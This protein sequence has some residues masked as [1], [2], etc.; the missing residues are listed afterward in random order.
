M[1]RKVLIAED[2]RSLR[3]I[4]GKALSS[5]GL[6]VSQ[7]GDGQQAY[8]LIAQGD[9]DVAIVDIKM[10]SLTG[11]QLLERVSELNHPPHV[12][13]ITA[14]NTMSNAIDA[15]KGGA[16]D[17]LCKPFDL[18]LFEELVLRAVKDRATPTASIGISDGPESASET[19]ILYG[20][21]PVMQRV[22]KAIG[23][24]AISP[25]SILISGDSGTGK[26]LVARILHQ[27]SPRS[28]GPF[29]AV[30]A[31]AIPPELLEADLFGHARGAF[32]GATTDN[33]GKFQAA[34]GGT[35][36][37]DE[38]GELPLGLQAKL[39]RVL[40]RKEFY[41]VGAHKE[42]QVDVRILVATNR[43]LGEEVRAGN[44]RGDLFY[45]LNVL[46]IDLPPLRDRIEDI[47][48]LANWLLEKHAREGS[49]PYRSL[50]D[51]AMEWL[52]NYTWPGN[53]RELENTL[54]RASTFAQ[55]PVLH[56]EDLIGP[57]GRLNRRQTGNQEESF[58]AMLFNR[59]RGVIRTFPEPP[60][61]EKSDLYQLVVGTAESVVL[62]L[63]MRRTAG[64]QLKAA[65]LLGLNRNTLR[66]KLDEHRINLNEIRRSSKK[67]RQGS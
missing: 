56:V 49:T 59:L 65:R 36:F 1:H 18:D 38:I 57:S 12:I 63:V 27:E 58:E 7:T 34:D 10:P 26:E 47:P 20:E 54:V 53:V 45:R 13:V 60:P 52:Q 2:D 51:D 42:V 40:E 5:Q 50:S 3:T 46:N 37:L 35:L 67:L 8:E 19:R 29:I 64:N 55:G 21:S 22:F 41:P 17:Y 31:A 44:F 25:H 61:G 39:L 15:M 33:P 66:R 6:E 62:D 16:Y 23:R 14:Q 9:F 43:D 4:M 24:A 32:T 28:A 48:L 30:N 11:L